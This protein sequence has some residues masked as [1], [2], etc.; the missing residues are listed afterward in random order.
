MSVRAWAIACL[1]VELVKQIRQGL[2]VV[3]EQ[4]EDPDADRM[5]ERAEQ[6]GLG[7]VQPDGHSSPPRQSIDKFWL[8]ILT[9]LCRQTS[10]EPLP[11]DPPGSRSS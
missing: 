9:E 3:L 6:L 10:R 4:L 7:L 5:T 11:V 2:G 8:S 1:D